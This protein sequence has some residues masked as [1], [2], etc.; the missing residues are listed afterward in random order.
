MIK[1]Y[2]NI[3]FNREPFFSE[4]AISYMGTKVIAFMV[5]AAP[6]APEVVLTFSGPAHRPFPE[7]FSTQS[8]YLSDIGDRLAPRRPQTRSFLVVSIKVDKK[9]S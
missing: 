2:P 5:S 9:T 1:A 4:A 3:F 8:D 6:R 7:S